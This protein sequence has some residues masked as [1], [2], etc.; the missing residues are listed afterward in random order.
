MPPDPG[1]ERYPGKVLAARI[2]RFQALCADIRDKAVRGSLKVG[3]V[4]ALRDDLISIGNNTDMSSSARGVMNQAY[5]R[6]D[7]V[8]RYLDMDDPPHLSPLL[9]YTVKGLCEAL[10]ELKEMLDPTKPTA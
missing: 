8:E 2:A 5:A 10:G 1:R 9:Q 4:E 6:T 7:A 3:D